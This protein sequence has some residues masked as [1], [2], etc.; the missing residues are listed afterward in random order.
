MK[1]MY[2]VTIIRKIGSLVEGMWVEIA[3]PIR[4]TPKDIAHA[5]TQ[6]YGIASPMAGI[7]APYVEIVKIA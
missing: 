7:N 4:P 2:R 5:F 3:S 6:K 1:G